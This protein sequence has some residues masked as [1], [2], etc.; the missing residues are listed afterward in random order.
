V[1]TE[2]VFVCVDVG[3]ERELRTLIFTI[4]KGSQTF[5][6]KWCERVRVRPFGIHA[7]RHLSATI[8]NKASY[9]LSL[10]QKILRHES[11]TTTEWYLRSLGFTMEDVRQAL[12]VFSSG[13]PEEKVTQLD[14][15][16][17]KRAKVIPLAQEKTL[18]AANSE[19]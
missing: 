11:T 10:I 5:M 2:Y 3:T 4:S 16:L 13:E 12:E 19:G 17:G 9:P 7:I 14:D 6:C 1:I 8:L 18:R 15:P